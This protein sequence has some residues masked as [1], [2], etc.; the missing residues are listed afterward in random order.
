MDQSINIPDF[1]LMFMTKYNSLIG[2]IGSKYLIPNR[3]N[4][5]DIKQ[6]ISERIIHILSNRSENAADNDIKNPEKYFKSCINFYCI[7]YQRMHGYIFELPKRPRKNCEED[8]KYIRSFG[9]KYLGDMNT[10]E[11]NSLIIFEEE[12]NPSVKEEVST[13]WK[14]LLS[15]LTK[16]EA[17]VLD[18]IFNKRLTWLETSEYLGVHQSTCWFRKNRAIEKIYRAF[19]SI[20]GDTIYGSIRKFLRGD[21]R[22]LGAFR[23]E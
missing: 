17:D 20:D 12:G 11:Y 14:T 7:E 13:V 1:V 16:E 3:Y 8:E 19:E 22:I 21:A 18:C 2:R 9:F 23:S 5:D 10:D 4:I 15:I 6:Y